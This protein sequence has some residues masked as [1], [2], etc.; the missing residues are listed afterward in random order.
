MPSTKNIPI[1]LT[2]TPTILKPKDPDPISKPGTN[3][4]PT[5]HRSKANNLIYVGR[6]K[7][8][9]LILYLFI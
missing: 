6:L 5:I 9:L 2:T 1:R 3:T 4:A 8:L 7:I